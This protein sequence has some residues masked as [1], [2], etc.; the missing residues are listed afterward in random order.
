VRLDGSAPTERSRSAGE[1]RPAQ[2]S[3]RGPNRLGPGLRSWDAESMATYL[4]NVKSAHERCISVTENPFGRFLEESVIANLGWPEN[5]VKQMLW[6]HGETDHFLPD[7]GNLD[8]SRVAW[9]CESLPTE[10][11]QGIPTGASDR[12]AIEAY[13]KFPV[14]WAE[15]KGADVIESW[16][17]NGTWIMPPLLIS[18]DLLEAGAEGW[19]LIEGRTRVG[20]LRGR[21]AQG[22]H[23]ATHQDAWVGRPRLA[24]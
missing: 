22:L 12:G 16:N 9:R 5:V 4:R 19:Q 17:R 3:Q 20:V 21:T 23:V 18:R 8:L 10:L 1:V 7:Y 2:P 11:F 15:I 13:A 14:Y 24:G 6:D